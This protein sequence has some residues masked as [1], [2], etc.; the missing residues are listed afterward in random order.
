[1]KNY[2]EKNEEV[3]D[4]TPIA[5]PFGASRP[6]ALHDLIA[7]CVQNQF[8]NVDVGDDFE[9]EEEANDFDI[10]DD[11]DPSSPWEE[12]FDGVLPSFL[13]TNEKAKFHYDALKKEIAKAQTLPAG[14]VEPTALKEPS[15]ENGANADK[16]EPKE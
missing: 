1:M 10:G 15:N 14:K 12:N 11:F 2:N 3:L 5:Q 4:Q 9:T 7:M 6:P 13:E 16:N 8:R